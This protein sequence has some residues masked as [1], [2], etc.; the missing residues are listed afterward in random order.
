MEH[1]IVGGLKGGG[2]KGEGTCRKEGSAAHSGILCSGGFRPLSLFLIR[3]RI[4]CFFARKRRA[5]TVADSSFRAVVEAVEAHY[6]ARR[7]YLMILTVNAIGLALGIAP[8]AGD[9][10]RRVNHGAE[11]SVARH[12]AQ[13]R[14]HRA[15]SIAPLPAP[16]PGADRNEYE[17]KNRSKKQGQRHADSA[18]KVKS[19]VDHP[20]VA[21]V[22]GKKDKQELQ[23]ADG[24]Q[25]RNGKHSVP[26]NA[27]L[28]A[29][30]IV[31]ER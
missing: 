3:N 7:V 27:V 31:L 15:D 8:S 10:L 28:L 14:T 6:A 9:A 21:A 4:G 5:E 12:K 23:R 1:F 11:K 20:S 18:D 16:H 24:A 25:D 26:R 13:G 19:C 30:A 29:V 22:R 2:A 17:S